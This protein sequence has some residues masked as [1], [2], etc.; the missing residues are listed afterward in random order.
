MET[1]QVNDTV[2]IRHYADSDADDVMLVWYETGKSMNVIS[3]QRLASIYPIMRDKLLPKWEKLVA[4]KN[5]VV[6]GYI[7]LE[8]SYVQGL[9]VTP[10]YQGQGTG[11]MML[12]KAVELRGRLSVSVYTANEKARRFYE[13]YGFVEVAHRVEEHTGMSEIILEMPD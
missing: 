1:T 11:R 7:A 6:I 8:G 5:R 3:N 9:F 13:K 10:E 4:V 2:S 12:D